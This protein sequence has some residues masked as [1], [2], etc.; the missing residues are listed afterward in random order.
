MMDAP[1]P[2]GELNPGVR[3][4]LVKQVMREIDANIRL[5]KIFGRPVTD[6]L[7]LVHKGK[8]FH[9]V[10]AHEIDLTDEQEKELLEIVEKI[11]KKHK[12]QK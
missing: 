4:K 8:Q 1:K 12:K 11:L 2:P 5:Q 3:L 6:K 9:F 10:N 7:A